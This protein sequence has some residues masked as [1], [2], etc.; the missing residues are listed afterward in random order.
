MYKIMR[1]KM[2]TC[3]VQLQHFNRKTNMQRRN[4][5]KVY[6]VH[7]T[8]TYTHT[9]THTQH[10]HTHTHTHTTHT[11][12]THTHTH[13][14][15]AYRQNSSWTPEMYRES[16]LSLQHQQVDNRVNSPAGYKTG[17]YTRRGIECEGC[18]G[19]DHELYKQYVDLKHH[20]KLH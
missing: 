13:T 9:H 1:I 12:T 19:E 17:T 8:H 20:E 14:H 18:G 16:L 15:R 5:G 4:E 6:C 2:E 3:K 7:H 11:H 10:T